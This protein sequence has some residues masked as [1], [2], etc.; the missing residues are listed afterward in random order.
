MASSSSPYG[1]RPINLIGGQHFSGGAMREYKVAADT[2]AFYM[3]DIIELSS[4]GL[5][6]R[7]TATPVAAV[8][9]ASAGNA[10]AGTVGIVGVCVGV[11][12]VNPVNKQ[13]MWGQYLPAN[14]TTAGYTDIWVMVND[15]YDQLYQIQGNAALGTFNSGTNGSGWPG[16]IGK[17]AAVAFGTPSA[18]Y[19]LSDIT[20]KI[21]TNGGS[22]ATTSSLAMRVVDVVRGTESDA[23]PEFVV[24][25]NWGLHGYTNP[26][27]V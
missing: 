14:A 1:L 11:R 12:Y 10:T 3:G 17:N 8:L 24:K 27:G 19:G 22:L 15:D 5:P 25:F 13:S 23:Y 20:L 21:D 9:P 6:A 16:A 18:T 4:A 2:T 26:L 7:R